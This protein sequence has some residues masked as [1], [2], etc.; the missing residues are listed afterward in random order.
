MNLEEAASWLASPGAMA[1]ISR[2][3]SLDASSP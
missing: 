3:P 1:M 2:D